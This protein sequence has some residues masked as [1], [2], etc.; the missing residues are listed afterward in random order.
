MLGWRVIRHVSGAQ[1]EEMVARGKWREVYDEQN[2]H[3][4]YQIVA[5]W[6][7]DLEILSGG[8]SPNSITKR[9]VEMNAGL[10]GRSRTQ[11]MPEESRVARFDSRTG[12]PLP[13]EDAIER[14]VAKVAEFGRM[15]LR[16]NPLKT[17]SL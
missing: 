8:P 1:G 5:S 14:A 6:K 10:Y 9:E 17:C 7:S 15:R 13:P 2:N 3:V 11:G 12:K 4:G 16:A